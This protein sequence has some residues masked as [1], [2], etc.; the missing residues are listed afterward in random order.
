[1]SDDVWTWEDQKS[2]IEDGWLLAEEDGVY[3][4]QRLDAPKKGEPRFRSDD[5][6][7]GF[8]MAISLMHSTLHAKAMKLDSQPV[9]IQK[10]PKDKYEFNV[11]VFLPCSVKVTGVL[12]ATQEEA[13]KKAAT[14]V[15]EHTEDI[16]VVVPTAIF[17]DGSY[18]SPSEDSE[19]VYCLV[20]YW[21]DDDVHGM[22]GFG[23]SRWFYSGKDGKMK[24]LPHHS[25]CPFC[26]RTEQDKEVK[27]NSQPVSIQKPETDKKTTP[28]RQDVS[29]TEWEFLDNALCDIVIQIN[30]ALLILSTIRYDMVDS[31]GDAPCAADLLRKYRP[32]G[33]SLLRNMDFSRA[34][35]ESD[36]LQLVKEMLILKWGSDVRVTDD[37][38]ERELE[39][40]SS[41]AVQ[42][43]EAWARKVESSEEG[44][45]H[46][47]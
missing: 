28:V 12:A 16:N 34:A 30:A 10:P 44:D 5:E 36:L 7:R 20:D 1:M 3:K 46:N 32:K 26:G 43:M 22:A 14:L 47:G 2:A 18:G 4:I 21:D 9:S 41:E 15:Y 17:G 35:I 40:R 8:V 39:V 29:D 45:A 25:I 23:R 27:M 11:H 6:A 31:E 13:A 19:T 24:I 42:A 38:V 33:C 37:M